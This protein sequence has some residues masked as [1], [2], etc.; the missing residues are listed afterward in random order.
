MSHPCLIW[1]WVRDQT[2]RADDREVVCCWR[3]WFCSFGWEAGIRTPIT[4]SRATCPTVERPPSVR[5]RS[6]QKS[7]IVANPPRSGQGAAVDRSDRR[8]PDQRALVPSNEREHC[9][10]VSKTSGR[11]AHRSSSSYCLSNVTGP[12][13]RAAALERTPFRSLFHQPA[14]RRTSAKR[15]QASSCA[16]RTDPSAARPRDG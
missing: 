6:R 5:P 16:A 8:A 10:L 9:G 11:R 1:W 13:T 15:T 14:C 7:S 12:D 4:W 2:S 3:I